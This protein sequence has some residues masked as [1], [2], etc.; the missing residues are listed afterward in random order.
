MAGQ[1]SETRGVRIPVM[2][3]IIGVVGVV[4]ASVVTSLTSG[5]WGSV[6]ALSIVGMVIFVLV[7]ALIVDR[8]PGERIGTIC[9]GIGLIYT[10][11]IALQL[12]AMAIYRQVGYLPP[13]AGLIGIVSTTL[14]SMAILMGGPLIISRF[15]RRSVSQAWRR[16]EDALLV[17]V[18][19]VLLLGVFR[20]G[21]VELG[22]VSA[23]E[24]P[25]G[26]DW[27]P[28]ETGTL[29]TLSFVTYAAAYGITAVGLVARYRRGAVVERA[30]IRWFV[31]AVAFSLVFMVLLLVSDDLDELNRVAWVLWIASLGLP[32]I[33]IAI[34]ILRY[35]LYDIDRILSNTLSYGLVTVILFGLFALLNV[36]L[37]E[38]AS[39]VLLGTSVGEF[40]GLAVV[41]STLLVAL[42]FQPVRARVQHDVDRRFHRAS[43]DA[44]R[45]VEALAMQL[46]DKVD[47][48]DL[49]AHILATVQQSIEPDSAVL[50][51]R[52]RGG[53]PVPKAAR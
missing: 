1:L 15:P 17:V 20:P 10:I 4:I 33:A 13:A 23:V 53:E 39:R 12:V 42:L 24:N 37:Q 26:V 36:A 51:L 41:A 7:G 28:I 31:A 52:A 18:G 11:A 2:A 29:F 49:Q 34:A 43:Y 3:A 47:L 27:L 38:L 21:P 14:S 40:Q 8:R 6:D 35:R 19:L 50:W 48:G 16:A 45:T 5:G 22:D 32:P 9:L 46:R 44:E 25:L 30:Q